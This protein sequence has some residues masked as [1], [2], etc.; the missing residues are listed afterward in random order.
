MQLLSTG[1]RRPGFAEAWVAEIERLKL[2]VARF[3]TITD[4]RGNYA[5]DFSESDNIFLY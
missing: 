5:N 3:T 1:D 4:P 2:K